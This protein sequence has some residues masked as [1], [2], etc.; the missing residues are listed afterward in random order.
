MRRVILLG[1][2]ECTSGMSL[3]PHVLY[4]GISE[5]APALSSRIIYALITRSL[6]NPYGP[7]PYSLVLAP[8]EIGCSRRE[9]YD[10][11]VR[12]TIPEPN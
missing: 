12:G 5:P 7:S 3:L 9:S 6:P 2:L 4:L 11:C 1:K 10:P 8:E